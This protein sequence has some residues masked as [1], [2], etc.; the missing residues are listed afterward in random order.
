MKAAVARSEVERKTARQSAAQVQRA[1]Q[2]RAPKGMRPLG[3]TV[4][5]GI[6]AHEAEAVRAIFIAFN[7]G[8]SLSAI[9]AALSGEVSERTLPKV[10]ALPRHRRT[11]TIERNDRR[12]AESKSLPKEKQRRLRPV[13]ANGPWP[14]ST[15]LGILR[16]PRYA[17]YTTYTPNNVQAGGGKR[18]SWRASILRDEAGEPVRGQWDPIVDEGTWSAVQDRLDSTDRVTNRVG[19]E[20]RHLGSGLY[21]CGVCDQRLRSHS[22]SYRCAG[23]ITRSREQVDEFVTATIRARLARPVPADPLPSQ[24]EP[25]LKEIKAEI[26]THRARIARAQRDYDDAVIEGR[27]LKRVREHEEAA[28]STLNAERVRLSTN[29]TAGVVLAAAHPVTASQA[30]DL[31]AKR[32]VIESLCEVRLLPHRRGVKAFDPE[33]VQISWR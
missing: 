30:A 27:D 8:S 3:Y 9:T 1:A 17:G 24:D 26:G 14:P 2:G 28:I 15:V 20:R 12:E 5:G 23:H 4:A 6:I 25:R 32:G 16:N 19:T 7:A 11:V 21:R 18:R 10:P 22:G 33:S 13:P 31:G 29:A